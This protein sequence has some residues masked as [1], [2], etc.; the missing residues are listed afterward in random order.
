LKDRREKQKRVLV[1]EQRRKFP[2]TMEEKKERI[3]KEREE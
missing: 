2:E 1:N 3:A